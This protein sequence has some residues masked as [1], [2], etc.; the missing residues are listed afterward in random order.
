MR[1]VRQEKNTFPD[2]TVRAEKTGDLQRIIWFKHR[3]RKTGNPQ[4]KGLELRDSAV[5]AKGLILYIFSAVL[6]TERKQ[7]ENGRNSFDK[8]NR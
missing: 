6:Q 4:P 2:K 5:L 7:K 1:Y 3:I 8:E